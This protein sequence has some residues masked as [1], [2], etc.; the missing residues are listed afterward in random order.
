MNI[1]TPLINIIDLRYTWFFIREN[2]DNLTETLNN[3]VLVTQ[4]KID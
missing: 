1:F 2:E 4:I 3:E